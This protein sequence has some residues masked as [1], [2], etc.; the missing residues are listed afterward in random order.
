MGLDPGEAFGN[1]FTQLC[2]YFCGVRV[3]FL[4]SM[5]GVST[6]FHVGGASE[7]N[8]QEGRFKGR[9]RKWRNFMCRLLWES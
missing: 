8:L 9:K 1:G 2:S 3:L 6:L 7:K 4:S 5:V